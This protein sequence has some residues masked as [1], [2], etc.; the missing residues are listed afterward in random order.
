MI[1]SR[2]E[3]E[4]GKPIIRIVEM[5]PN[6][7][8]PDLPPSP[9]KVS[10]HRAPG[11]LD[12]SAGQGRAGRGGPQPERRKNRWSG[13]EPLLVWTVEHPANLAKGATQKYQ[14]N[15]SDTNT[16]QTAMLIFKFPSQVFNVTLFWAVADQRPPMDSLD[17]PG[18][19]LAF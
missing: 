4:K 7:M 2:E 15:V 19:P 5:F 11:Q 12:I 3:K 14:K 6:T 16:G 9:L 10:D 17:E 13:A 1:W 8:I 18:L